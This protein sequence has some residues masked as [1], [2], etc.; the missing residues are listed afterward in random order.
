MLSKSFNNFQF[1]N[2]D[3]Y[4]VTIAQLYKDISDKKIS[5]KPNNNPK[6]PKD[7]FNTEMLEQAILDPA[8]SDLVIHYKINQST[9][10]AFANYNKNNRS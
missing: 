10:D 3:P 5:F 4:T 1:Y 8:L 2:Q 9:L 6:R 7:L